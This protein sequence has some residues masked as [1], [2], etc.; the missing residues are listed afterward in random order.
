[1]ARL[2]A[3]LLFCGDD[4][5]SPAARSGCANARV[6]AHCSRERDASTFRRVEFPSAQIVE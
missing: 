3:G 5:P 2:V 4:F 1:M 6:H